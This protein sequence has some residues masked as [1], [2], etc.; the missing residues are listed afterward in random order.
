[1]IH[2]TDR[3]QRKGPEVRGMARQSVPKEPES[4]WPRVL[5]LSHTGQMGGAE[6][7]LEELITLLSFQRCAVLLA[8]GPLL[9]R[10][11]DKH[12]PALAVAA[13][14]QLMAP[15]RETGPWTRLWAARR[16][17]RLVR[18]LARLA[19]NSDI[20]YANSKKVLLPAAL[21][22]R[23]ANRPLIWHQHDEIHL[24]AS[25]APRSRLSEGLLVWLLNRYAARIISV[26]RAAA[27]S[28]IAAGGRTE[29]PVVVH[30]GLDPS[31]YVPG[32]RFSARVC[33]GLPTG[34]ALIGCFGRLT[35]WKGQAVLIEALTR[36][37]DAHVVLV[38]GALFGEAD[39]EAGLRLTAERLGLSDRV[40][41]L[42]HR[43][44]VAALMQAVDVIA[45]PSTHFDP[46]PR[47]VLEALHSNVPL[48]ATAVG[49]TPELVETEISGLLVPPRDPQALA[50]ALRRML[51]DPSL[52]ASL[53]AEGR[54]RA[55]SQFTL[56]RVVTCVEREIRA[57]ASPPAGRA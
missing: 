44:D 6:F 5:F 50:D 36:I 8:S 12:I 28:F 16:L 29:L 53:A 55:L 14:G 45:H 47:V 9:K 26:S 2:A 49:G 15:G 34:V 30:N 21:T 24:P 37:P 3:I 7:C 56:D 20:I 22:A 32:D 18:Q 31:D 57:V 19:R 17:P 10:L 40:H 11:R 33:A 52:A 4:T 51:D 1:M 42:G 41:F 27:D 38:G 25:A 54:C 48:V 23:L 46:C 35:A 13:G 43:D 39:Y